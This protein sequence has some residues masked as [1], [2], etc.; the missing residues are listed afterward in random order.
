[1]LEK[2]RSS[3]RVKIYCYVI[4]LG[5]LAVVGSY[6]LSSAVL[7]RELVSSE[8][9]DIK[10]S[11]NFSLK[12]IARDERI[13]SVLT[14]EYSK[15]EDDNN[16]FNYIREFSGSNVVAVYYWNE[17]TNQINSI[18]ERGG[19]YGLSIPQEYINKVNAIKKSD[20]DPLIV[21]Q[22]TS[23]FPQNYVLLGKTQ[24]IEGIQFGIILVYDLHKE[25]ELAHNTSF[26]ACIITTEIIVVMLIILSFILHRTMRI[27]KELFNA[28]KAISER[29]YSK[30]VEVKGKDEF[31]L[32]A[33]TFNKMQ[34]V[35]K[36]NE[37]AQK[38]FVSDVTHELK[39]PTASLIMA[40][41]YLY[42]AKN[43]IPEK[44]WPSI[45]ILHTRV[46]D[47]KRLLED[48]L[49]ISRYDFGAVIM[50]KE[51]VNLDEV[52][53]NVKLSLSEAAERAGTTIAIKTHKEEHIAIVDYIKFSRIVSN[54]LTNAIDYSDGKPI[55]VDILEDAKNVFIHVID[56]GPGIDKDYQEKVFNRFF[57]LDPARKRTIG[58]TGLGLTIAKT[59]IEQHG[60]SLTLKSDIGKGSTF[61]ITVP[62]KES[63]SR[64]K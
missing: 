37:E 45:R 49:E 59:D 56:K 48:L 20:N 31:A 62:K 53:K 9:T 43:S 50:H 38:R 5:I 1:M 7:E 64:K 54:L 57:R 55:V 33:K 11:A 34:D 21:N 42:S 47:F 15:T 61:T 35:V 3:Y 36:N 14:N 10:A 41:E 32:L 58:G 8:L 17:L 26:L 44:L 51:P 63:T 46:L 23:Y 40:S 13:T 24:D 16:A 25:Y 28:S 2:I 12:N 4:S 19:S 27:T 30:K 6:L 29:D 18:F 39:A 60:G 22:N 52:V